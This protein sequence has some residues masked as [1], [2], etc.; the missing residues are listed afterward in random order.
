MIADE[1]DYRGRAKRKRLTL[2]A[3][4]VALLGAIGGLS[5]SFMN[6]DIRNPAMAAV[7]PGDSSQVP[8]LVSQR[9][10]DIDLFLNKVLPSRADATEE[11]ENAPLQGDGERLVETV[12]KPGDTLAKALAAAGANKLIAHKAATT[13]GELTD[14]RRLRPGQELTLWFDNATDALTGVRLKESVER[15]VLARA[16]EEG[17]FQGKEERAV[18]TRELVKARATID[19]SLF[20]AADR[21]NLEHEVIAELIRMF[22]FDVDFQRG[23]HP[24]DS[25]EVTYERFLDDNNQ[26]AKTGRIMKATLVRKDKPLTYYRY[27]AKGTT[28]P[29]YFNAEGQSAKKTLMQ[30]P[31][32]GARI[33]S[34][35]G[36]RKHPILGYTKMHKGTDFAARSGT[37][38]MA[39]GDGTIVSLGWNGG[40]GRY[41]RIRH[42]GT[43]QT[44]YAH[45]KAFRR[46]LKKGSVVKQ[47]QIIGYVGTSGRST[48]PHLHYEV[49][50]SGK[51]VN[52]RSIKLPT[53]IKLAGASLKA[54]QAHRAELDKTI[55]AMPYL[56]SQDVARAS[57]IPS[58]D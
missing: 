15:T 11:A 47:G 41:I 53:G 40:Y 33:S 21:A 18:F 24:G 13:L 43:Y 57:A 8:L 12:I 52:P 42:N 39:A 28:H 48:G 30:T 22:S 31:I 44:A 19:D 1:P 20:L 27:H 36:R 50:K 49:L 3:A 45:M 6:G 14:L 29:G 35:F 32:D 25:F 56:G 2:M 17:S 9:E 16:T 23:I 46:G 7:E 51:Q 37:P 5:V 38:I 58:D 54:F 10:K 34:G 55:A 26:V 4:G